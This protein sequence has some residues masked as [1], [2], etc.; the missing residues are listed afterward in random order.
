MR[1]CEGELRERWEGLR[2]GGA[3]AA[4]TRGRVFDRL[5]AAYAGHDRHYH[6]IDHIDECLRE[7]DSVRWLSRQPAALETAIWF[8]DV[9]Y[10]GRQ[11]DN[12]ERSAQVANE[13]LSRLDAPEALRAEVARLVLLTRHDRDPLPDDVDGQLIVDID[14]ASLARPPEVFDENT[15]RI[16]LEYPHVSDADFRRGRRDLLGTF[17]ARPRIYHTEALSRRYE[18]QAREN[19]TRALAGL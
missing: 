4:V 15:R 3:G 13:E 9:V 10:D 2:L 6:G 18:R 12:E 7:L 17:L 5:W 19:L 11:K 16:R 8:H 14:L 1:A